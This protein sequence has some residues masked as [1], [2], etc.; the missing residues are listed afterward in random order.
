M[1][2]AWRPNRATLRLLLLLVVLVQ[3]AKVHASSSYIDDYFL[4]TAKI[5]LN[6]LQQSLA[7]I[8]S[9]G[10]QLAAAEAALASSNSTESSVAAE[11][12]SAAS[13]SSQA[14]SEPTPSSSE[15]SKSDFVNL[16]FTWKPELEATP[17]V[18]SSTE[19]VA[20]DPASGA[21]QGAGQTAGDE[22]SSRAK[23]QQQQQRE[24][25]SIKEIESEA[26][27]AVEATI[28]F[29]SAADL[30]GLAPG[31]SC[32][33]EYGN[34]RFCEP[35]FESLALERPVE[36]SSECGRPAS[37]F[38]TSY[39]PSEHSSSEQTIRN[40]HICDAQH[41]K[42]RHPA[43]YLTDV[44]PSGQP[45]TCWVS[46]P[47]E[48]EAAAAAADKA[49]ERLDNVTLTLSLDKKFEITYVSVQ[50]CSLKPDSL[51]LLRSQDFGR[52]WSAY[53]FYSSQCQRVYGRPAASSRHS[54]KLE[55]LCVNSSQLV[56][57]PGGAGPSSA[58][59]QSR[60]AF[61]T[62]DALG[63]AEQAAELAQSESRAGQLQDWM[64]ATNLRL[65]LDRHQASW[66]QASLAQH[67]SFAGLSANASSQQASRNASSQQQAAPETSLTSPS[68]SYNY[69]ISELTVGGRCK[70]NGH[71]S[72]CVHADDGRLQCDCRHNTAGRDCERCAPFHF[73]RPWQR[74][75]Q[76]DANPC[77]RE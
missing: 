69:A 42:K 17:P 59:S 47:I 40:C 68:N 70:C 10:A 50:F 18:V 9:A 25:A 30:F 54:D 77:Q 23:Q 66:I 71:A 57:G 58:L 24:E 74:A 37:R 52:T 4:P 11:S 12:S 65:V 3:N 35:E 5:A 34:A 75:S 6:K 32:Y 55:A 33:D 72:R 36:A 15:P 21:A 61:S 39:A 38:C 67:H 13:S 8:S 20:E 16:N 53:Q 41:A 44:S 19:S 1:A 51:A 7:P 28:G 14:S 73:D 46:A 56:Q 49:G 31:D 62:L 64:T 76:L 29:G 60:V 22:E 27:A 43:A 26:V 63:P 48:Q 2:K 45:P